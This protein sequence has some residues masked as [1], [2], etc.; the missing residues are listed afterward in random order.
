MGEVFDWRNEFKPLDDES[1]D[2][3]MTLARQIE[4][5]SKV[6]F[7][8]D[9]D[10]Q[11]LGIAAHQISRLSAM[12]IAGFALFNEVYS[13]AC[14]LS[15]EIVRLIQLCDDADVDPTVS[16]SIANEAFKLFVQDMNVDDADFPT[17]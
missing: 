4:Q 5:L 15:D 7:L 1:I 2:S 6:T 10:S 11:T 17:N 13:H 14:S 16:V 8:S 3:L 12:S 9:D